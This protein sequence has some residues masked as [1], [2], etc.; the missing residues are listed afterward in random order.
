MRSNKKDKFDHQCLMMYLLV[1][2]IS[3]WHE[4][5]SSLNTLH[6]ALILHLTEMPCF[7]WEKNAVNKK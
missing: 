4:Y 6:L 3:N 5:L 2:I 7:I 1:I